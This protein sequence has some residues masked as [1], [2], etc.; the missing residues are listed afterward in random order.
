MG[1]IGSGKSTFLHRFFRVVSPGLVTPGGKAML[2]Y[3]DFLGAP[4]EPAQLDDFLWKR[5]ASGLKNIESQLGTRVVLEQ[6]FKTEIDITREVYGPSDLKTAERISSLLINSYND[7]KK[8]GESGL[9]FCAKQRRVPIV[10]FDNVDQLTI[11]AQINLF[12]SAQRFA[13]LCL[14]RRILFKC[15][16]EETFNRDDN[17]SVSPFFPKLS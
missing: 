10:V 7:D 5:V 9:S 13:N 4:D 16:S 12:T 1:G 17:S 15:T 14:T 11:N 6:I 2:V 8:F 3:L